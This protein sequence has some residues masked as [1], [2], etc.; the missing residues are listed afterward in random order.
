M[1]YEGRYILLALIIAFAVLL[2]IWRYTG[3]RSKPQRLPRG[4]RHALSEE[5][6][7]EYEENYDSLNLP[8]KNLKNPRKFTREE[9]FEKIAENFGNKDKPEEKKETPKKDV[10]LPVF[11]MLSPEAEKFLEE[12]QEML[13]STKK[14]LEKIKKNEEVTKTN[15]QKN[16]DKMT[17]E[18]TKQVLIRDEKGT[19]NLVG[20]VSLCPIDP[21][22][23]ENN[24]KPKPKESIV[25]VKDNARKLSRNKP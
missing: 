13:E 20:I 4:F 1:F 18:N 24:G 16:L 22:I 19:L 5:E 11:G 14:E 12:K 3:K 23:L 21:K 2:V 8:R 15:F 7:Q 9:R 17:L 10:G 6:Q 25:P